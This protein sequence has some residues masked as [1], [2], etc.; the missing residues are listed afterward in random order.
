MSS[1][2]RFPQRISSPR[3]APITRQFSSIPPFYPTLPVE[4]RDGFASSENLPDIRVD[5]L[6]VGGGVVGLAVARALTRRWP[7]KTTFLVERHERVGEETSSR[8]SEVIHAGLYYPRE[9]LK[10]NLCLRGRDLLYDYC[11]ANKVPVKQLGKLVVGPSTSKE[12][13]QGVLAHVRSLDQEKDQN[14]GSR[15]VDGKR[16]APPLVLLS[17]K[18][19]RGIEPDLGEGVGW[20]LH[21]PKTGIVNSHELMAKLEQD[22][23]NS[24]GAEIVYDTAVVGLAPSSAS[25]RSTTGKR[26]GDGSE[27]GW[28]VQ[29]KTEGQIDTLLAKVVINAA[30]LNGPAALNSL[31]RD[32]YLK[33]GREDRIGAWISKG[34][35][36]SYSKSKGGVDRVSRL[37]YPIPDMGKSQKALGQ[38]QGLGTHLTLDMDGNVRFGPDTDWL[39]PPHT[40]SDQIQDWWSSSLVALQPSPYS[41]SRLSEEERLDAMHAS[42]SSFLP[43]VSRHGLSPDY[44]GLRP[45]LGAPGDG[46]RDFGILW[47]RSENLGGAMVT[48]CG[49]ESPGL[50]SSLALA[51]IVLKLVGAKMWAE[52]VDDVNHPPR[53]KGARSEEL[54]ALESW[55]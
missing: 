1:I 5:H 36:A 46:F 14:W 45:K 41:Q 55:A 31:L 29:T 22:I 11:R 34:N 16:S 53:P 38:H 52:K 10:T 2:L 25:R 9:S 23:L 44:A 8:N 17:G 24:E 33:G 20:A 3:T 42:V 6:I 54:G 15:V 21:S 30:G 18:E 26:G 35:Y 50:T 37:I 27:Q 39:Y 4:I 7:D 43:G 51:E 12:Y 47:H 13:L 49:I 32:G 28:I 19:A 40:S 48:L